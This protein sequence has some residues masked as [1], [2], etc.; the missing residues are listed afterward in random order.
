MIKVCGI[1]LPLSAEADCRGGAPYARGALVEAVAAQ[2][3]VP[4]SAVDH[5][6]VLR[7]S[8]DARRKS[9]VHFVVNAAVL[10]LDTGIEQSLVE[11]GAATRYEPLYPL[12][13]PLCPLDG[14]APP[15]VVGAGPAGLFCALYLARAG[16]RPLVVERGQDVEE[17]ARRIAAL[18]EE[19]IL[20]ENC[21]IQFGEGGAGTFSDGKLTTNIKH[22]L[23]EHVLSWF[24]Q[25]G[26]PH[27]ILW[28]ARP[29]IGSDRLPA[30]VR[31]MREEIVD[32]GGQVLFGCRLAGL[33]VQDGAITGAV[34]EDANGAS[35]RVVPAKRVVLAVGH[36]A[37]DTFQMLHEAGFALEQK[38]FSVGVRIEHRQADI[39]RAQ[40]GAACG[41]AALGAAEYK[42]ACHVGAKGESQR[43][44]YT[45]CMCP[46]GTV[47]CASS[48]KGGVATNGM[49][50]FA[51]D[52]A[53][54][55]A[56][57]LVNVDPQDFGASDPLA[58]VRLQ[59]GIERAA[60]QVALAA[61]G[62]P[63]AAPAQTVGSFLESAW[64]ANRAG[65][66]NQGA[67][68]PAAVQPESM[69]VAPTYPRGVA[70][71]DL[72]EVLP[73]FVC[74]TL[75]QALPEMGRKLHGFDD[76]AAV[77]TAPETRSSSPV[78]IC[79][80]RNY[81]AWIGSPDEPPDQPDPAAP[82][83]RRVQPSGLYPCGEG[84]GYAGGIMSAACDGLSV[85]CQIV[86]EM[87]ATQNALDA[88]VDEGAPSQAEVEQALEALRAGRAVVFPTDTVVG[89]GVSVGHAADP[90][91]IYRIKGRDANKPVAWLVGGVEA[92]DRYGRDVPAYAYDL[93][94]TGW[95]G[96]LT[97]IIKA[98]PEVPRAFQS[99]QG[100]I[101]LRMPASTLAL[102]LIA[103][104]GFP[105]AASSAN[106]SGE[107]ARG[108]TDQVD[109][110]VLDQA[111]FVLAAATTQQA[112]GTASQVVDCTGAEPVVLRSGR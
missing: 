48:E 18:E 15:I 33:E 91:E 29:H 44:A 108:R 13:V 102:E 52:G 69:K 111:G 32:R 98:S 25:A 101:G 85:A 23:R 47:V 20:D 60:Y 95:P 67:C 84:A 11:R 73:G 99:E 45:F 51:R 78:R 105:I 64:S 92:L 55:N 35:R 53:N 21:N 90:G 31:R 86:R 27:Q 37:R 24:A 100:T 50:A 58:G 76:P 14:Q 49:S 81:Q 5:V 94:R 4:A 38:A 68:V 83:A 57:L 43:H 46:G 9:N 71:C 61:G 87:C 106:I 93:A 97:L 88:P 22:P 8:V 80:A 2:L 7:R 16:L 77:L 54:A 104:L 10:L 70:F 62:R 72:R 34:L 82:T 89:L 42:L 36:S 17:R 56:G 19:G 59:Q 28:D 41:H 75:A 103:Q 39:D 79:R 63:Y 74:D 65:S 112:S 26:A 40:W 1:P 109:A 6:E 12:E 107:M 110:A 96:A 30:V 3:D 66:G